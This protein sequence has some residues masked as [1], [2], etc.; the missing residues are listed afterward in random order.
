M[1]LHKW[2]KKKGLLYETFDFVLF[3]W[4]LKSQ[5]YEYNRYRQIHSGQTL[6]RQSKYAESLTWIE[7]QNPS[8]VT[9]IW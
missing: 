7:M 8:M 5:V 3:V 4:N 1:Y 6:T 2:K 9:K